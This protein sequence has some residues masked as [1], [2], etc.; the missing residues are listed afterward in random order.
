MRLDT[1]LQREIIRLHTFN[2]NYSNREIARILDLSPTTVGTL[3]EKFKQS[4]LSYKQLS[5]L[6]DKD[7][8]SQIGSQ[9]QAPQQ[10]GKPEPIWDDIYDEL[11]KRDM[12]L[13]LLW[14]EYRID[15]PS[16]LSYSQ[17][18]R[19]YRAWRK[20]N[21]LSMKQTYKQGEQVLVDFCGRTMPIQDP[22]TGKIKYVQVFV[23]VLGASGYIFAFAVESQKINDWLRCHI[24]MFNYF[25]G[26]PQ[27]VV[28]D[29]LKSAVITNNKQNLSLN[30]SYVEL[31]RYYDFA[32]VPT[33]PR[34]P[35]DKG[36]AEVSVQIVQRGILAKLRHRTF[37]SIEELNE[38]I[39]EQLI[40][41]NNKTTK[42]FTTSR[43]EQYLLYD[44]PF[45]TQL[46][47]R[48]FELKKWQ[49]DV[50]VNE[51][52]QIMIDGVCYSVPYNY[53]HH[54]INI[55]I[56]DKLVEMYYQH[57]RIASHALAEDGQSE[58]ID[59]NHMPPDHQYQAQN[60]PD[61]LRQW[62]KKLGDNCYLVIDEL[63]NDKSQYAS[64]LRKLIDFKKWVIEN[65]YED[66]LDEASSFAINAGIFSLSRLK[67]LVS[68]KNYQRIHLDNKA[69]KPK[70]RQTH[71]N[72]RGSEYYSSMMNQK[73]VCYA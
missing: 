37:F 20:T 62:S 49:Y 18:A 59:Y 21:R 65:D 17:F 52:Y 42:R 43:Y 60:N 64:N 68:S 30:Q 14:Q 24:A 15:N 72:V 61:Y 34:H 31:A 6:A 36:L 27:Q 19:K 47:A 56:S 9:L 29:N 28:T 44:K 12:T 41:L 55:A 26:I 57:Q 13:E 73:E 5:E 69:K 33:R 25:A 40:E 23:A 32:I 10:K 16:G 58:V 54:T 48:T 8:R 39:S 67:S 1:F 53:A 50:K 22:K 4:N 66:R 51:F 3:L 45:L 70:P 63:L 2:P 46:P 7:F 38:A 71:D 11:K 35:K